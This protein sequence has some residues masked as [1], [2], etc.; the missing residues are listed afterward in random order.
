MD[1]SED[2]Q[3]F[4]YFIKSQSNPEMDPL[5]LWMTGGPGCSSISGLVY[6]IGIQSLTESEFVYVGKFSIGVYVCLATDNL[7]LY[8]QNV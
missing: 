2:V 5:V 7:L 1:E 3:L 6:E 8:N 4:Y